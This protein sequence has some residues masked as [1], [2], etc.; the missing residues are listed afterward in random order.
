MKKI[1]K[2]ITHLLPDKAFVY[3]RYKTMLSEK[4]YI[5]AIPQLDAYTGNAEMSHEAAV[6][7]IAPEEI[8]YLMPVLYFNCH[9]RFR[10][11]KP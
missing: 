8:E 2:K 7:R 11:K 1:L 3:L 6:G 9:L 10:E 5:S 4:G